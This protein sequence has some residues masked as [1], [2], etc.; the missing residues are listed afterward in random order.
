MAAISGDKTISEELLASFEPATVTSGSALDRVAGFK[1]AILAIRGGTTV[2]SIVLAAPAFVE[3]DWR[4]VAWTG[5]IA[6]YN[7]VR[8]AFP[9]RYVTADTWPASP[10]DSV[11]LFE[12]AWHQRWP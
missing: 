11:L 3:R 7:I 8:L 6:V 4:I 5:L 12:S 10:V 1:P 9:I 2:M